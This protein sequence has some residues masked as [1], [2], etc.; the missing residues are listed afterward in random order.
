MKL[1]SA[2]EK[3]TTTRAEGCCHYWLIEPAE[4]PTCR[5]VC[6]F[7]GAEE[8]FDSYLADFGWRD[9]PLLGGESI[10]ESLAFKY[11]SPEGEDDL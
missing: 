4:G 8:E 9:F 10:A 11:G 3:P 1:L 7:C 2:P 5:G 6:K